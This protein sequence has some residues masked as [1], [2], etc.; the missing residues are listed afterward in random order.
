MCLR[1]LV[2]TEWNP[3]FTQFYNG[4]REQRQ[5]ALLEWWLSDIVPEKT[6]RS[7]WKKLILDFYC[8]TK[9]MWTKSTNILWWKQGENVLLNSPRAGCFS[10]KNVNF[11]KKG[12]SRLHYP[13]TL[14]ENTIRHF[15]EFKVTED[16]RTKQQVFDEHDALIR[17]VLPVKAQKSANVVRHQLGDLSRKI[18]VDVQLFTQVRRSK[19]NSSRKNTKFQ[20]LINKNVVYYFKCGL[21]VAD[22]VGFTSRPFH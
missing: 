11:W 14:V 19:D 21:C 22:Y 4:T 15:I 7:T 12:F 17:I 20:L 5:T 6:R 16:V 1:F 10:I 13:E 3:P 18:D 9:A 2:N 8:I